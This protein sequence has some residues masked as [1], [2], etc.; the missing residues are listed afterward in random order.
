MRR[1]PNLS[2]FLVQIAR[3]K[4]ISEKVFWITGASS[5]IGEALAYALGRMGCR[6]ILSSREKASLE[7]VKSKCATPDKV[8][9]IELDL[10]DTSNMGVLA[11]HAIALFGRVD[12][13]VNNAGV[14]QRSVVA[15]TSLHVYKKLMDINYLG[16]VALT[17]AILPH[18]IERKEG[19]FVTVSSLM[20]KFGSPQRSGYCAAK[21][22]LHGFF[23]VLRMEHQRDGIYVTMICPGFVNTEIAM[24]ALTSDGSPKRSNDH[25][26][27]GGMA[28]GKFAEKMIRAM[29]RRKFEAYIGG[30][31]V[32]GVYLKRFFPRLL[33]WAVLR[34]R[35]T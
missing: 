34:S 21:H 1:A 30:S 19:Y 28:P 33:H 27:S 31:E 7:K 3:M 5:G 11:Q 25:R 22:A 12:V 13:L 6:L 4:D 15:Q 10:A 23:D 35:V 18:F 20:G 9:I 26:T 17:K 32:A 8:N 29:R 2:I 14:S 24:N 16:T